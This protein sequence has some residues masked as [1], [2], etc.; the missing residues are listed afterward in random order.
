[1]ENTTRTNSRKD[2]GNG[3]WVQRQEAEMDNEASTAST[4]SP[5]T[6]ST[7]SVSTRMGAS[8]SAHSD[9]MDDIFASAREAYESVLARGQDFLSNVDLKRGTTVIRDYPVQAAVGGLIVGFLLGALVSRRQ[10]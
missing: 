2:S 6:T 1:M 3:R 5:R 10:S 9:V 7:P 4:L 8:P